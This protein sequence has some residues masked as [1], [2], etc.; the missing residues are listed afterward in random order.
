[1]NST[2]SKRHA[3]TLRNKNILFQLKK[4]NI[5]QTKLTTFYQ[6]YETF[7]CT[8][9]SGVGNISLQGPPLRDTAPKTQKKTKKKQFLR[10]K[11]TKTF[12]SMTQVVPCRP[13]PPPPRPPVTGYK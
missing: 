5:Y 11:K 7:T 1:M 8:Q 6:E 3:E 9:E 4:Q 13:A 10:A 2:T 12:P